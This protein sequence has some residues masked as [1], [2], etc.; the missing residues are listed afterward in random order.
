MEAVVINHDVT[1]LATCCL[2]MKRFLKQTNFLVEFHGACAYDC[3][4]SSVDS[5][6]RF[7][8]EKIRYI[9]LQSIVR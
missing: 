3:D 9:P 1:P 6:V 8:F 5:H 2:A 7:R 4:M